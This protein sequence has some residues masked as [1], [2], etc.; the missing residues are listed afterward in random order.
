MHTTIQSIRQ[1]FVATLQENR[2][3]IQDL[4]QEVKAI[5]KELRDNPE[6]LQQ[7][8][9]AAQTE[10]NAELAADIN[11]INAA[12]TDLIQSSDL[13]DIIDISDLTNNILIPQSVS[14]S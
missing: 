10:F 7:E 6:L 11:S 3:Q 2:Q 14:P 12:I 5:D 4:K 9:Q 8:L 1:E 13:S